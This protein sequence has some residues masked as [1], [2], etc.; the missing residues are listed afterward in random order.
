MPARIRFQDSAIVTRYGT[1]KK[2]LDQAAVEPL[3][4]AIIKLIEQ[5]AGRPELP[6]F[7]FHY[8]TIFRA[9][10]SMELPNGMSSFRSNVRS[11]LTKLNRSRL[12]IGLRGFR[13]DRG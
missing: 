12:R 2:K 6:S 9:T 11:I 7:N 13:S 5:G 8:L 1:S 4:E 3:P 10:A